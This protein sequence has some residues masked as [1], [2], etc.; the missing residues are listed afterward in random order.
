MLRL[1]EEHGA[2]AILAAIVVLFVA[3][4]LAAIGMTTYVREGSLAELQRAADAGALAGAASIPLG[5]LTFVKAYVDNP[6]GL[7]SYFTPAANPLNVACEQ[8]KR[9]LAEDGLFGDEFSAAGPVTLPACS[10]GS[11]SVG[12]FSISTSY[13]PD[14]AFADKLI[15]CLGL[16]NLPLPLLTNLLS[17]ARNV[18]PALLHAGVQVTVTRSVRGPL[19]GVFGT[20]SDTVQTAE[21]AAKRRFKNLVV[22]PT[23][24][25]ANL[26]TGILGQPYNGAPGGTIDLNPAAGQT[27]DTALGLIQGLG[28]LPI[29]SSLCPGL[30]T[31]LTDDLGD[32]LNPPVAGAPT[33]ADTI[34]Q[35]VGQDDQLFVLRYVEG[36]PLVQ[37][38]CLPLV[39]C[40]PNITVPGIAPFLDFVPVCGVNSSTLQ[41]SVSGALVAA[42]TCS[43]QAPGAFR[44]QLVPVAS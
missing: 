39:G 27:I 2:I 38:I 9:A 34:R 32:L 6:L 11:S 17:G 18:L 1:R 22:V 19:D 5:D 14:V 29:L 30:V 35:T 15:D 44:A 36:L 41:G 28:N 4:P 23:I 25:T 43:V 40:I 37:N 26:L 42:T 10:G 13:L 7:G 21:A 20:S 31:S 12:T 24:S 33:L 3:L 16:Q 8:A